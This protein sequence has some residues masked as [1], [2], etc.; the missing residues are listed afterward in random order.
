MD[1]SGLGR[2]LLS[3]DN[4][5][6]LYSFLGG[7]TAIVPTPVTADTW[8]HAAITFDGSTYRL[9]LDGIERTST[10]ISGEATDG[11]LAVG[12]SK[13]LSS[14]PFRGAL[15]E[16]MIYRRPLADNEIYAL[17]QADAAGVQ[18]VEIGLEAFDFTDNTLGGGESFDS[19]TWQPA[20]VNGGRWGY[21]LPAVAEGFYNVHLR[22]T[23][24]F[25]N[26]KNESI[27]WR[28][29]IDSV[30]PL[31]AGSGQH[32]GGGTAAQTEYTLTFSDFILDETSYVQPCNAGSLVSLAYSDPLL[33]QNGRTYDVTATC[34]LPG[35]ETG[36]DITICD[37]V[38]LCTTLTITA[39]AAP[40]VDSIAILDPLNHTT[41]SSSG[42]YTVSGGAYDL[43]EIQTIVVRV[44]GS[45]IGTIT[46]TVGT[47][48]TTWAT[49]WTP[50][51]SGTYTISATL[52]DQLNNVLMDTVQVTVGDGT[53]TAITLKAIALEPITSRWLLLWLS[54][55]L[56][57][58]LTLAVVRRPGQDFYG[59]RK[60]F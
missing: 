1:G 25:G 47:V 30:T 60:L 12:I 8:H 5:N 10:A 21:A 55:V 32:I 13:D 43:N 17:A 51:I 58:A 39:T 37:G 18:S 38:G 22:S 24:N 56:L 57:L 54:A 41:F 52:T 2:N 9:Y 45:I 28:G 34:R 35:H 27:I 29:L 40:D 33:P 46:P 49:G 26:L 4:T 3:L 53:P 11:D 42:T 16:M 15:D 31:L 19:T 6:H 20:V 59:K 14:F 23:D 44:D 50:A 48:D 36:R 7:V